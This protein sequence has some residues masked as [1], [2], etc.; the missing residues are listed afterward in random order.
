MSPSGVSAIPVADKPP[1]TVA[2]VFGLSVPSTATP[3]WEMV[4]PLVT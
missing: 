2:G 3:Y 1:S 4:V